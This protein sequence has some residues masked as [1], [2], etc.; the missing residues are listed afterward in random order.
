MGEL[1][2][3]TCSV[4]IERYMLIPENLLFFLYKSLCVSN[5]FCFLI[6][7]EIILSRDKIMKCMRSQERAGQQKSIKK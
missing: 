4:N 7:E 2:L 5:K 3:L 6:T 1:R